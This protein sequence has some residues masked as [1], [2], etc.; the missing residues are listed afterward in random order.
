M[1]DSTTLE[2]EPPPYVSSMLRIDGYAEIEEILRSK[3]FV[4]GSHRESR[5]FF[6]DSLL[7][8][9]GGDHLARRRLESRL[10]AKTALVHYESASLTPTIAQSIHESARASGSDGPVR[11]D[12]TPLVRTMLHRISAV[13]TGIDGVE[14]PEQTERFRIFVEKLGESSTV[15]WSTR[16]RDEVIREGLEQ[17]AQ[18]VREFFGP[19]ENRRRA[20]IARYRAGEI[21]RDELPVDLLTLLHLHW[22]EQWDEDL[23]LRESTLFL[24][25][26][27]QTTT[28][29]LPHV[30]LHVDE[31]IRAHPEDRG[32]T[33][34]PEFL[35]LA[36]EESLRLH[37]PA[38]TLL[39]S[40]VRDV[41]L[42]S[43]RRI[44]KGERVALFFTPANRDRTV[45]GEDADAFNPYR[46]VPDR[47]RPWGLTFGGGVHLCIGRPLVTGLSSRND[48]ETGTEGTMVGILRALY[49]AGAQLDPDHPPRR[50]ESSY[51]DS[52]ASFPIVLTAL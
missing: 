18:F 28:H 46:T 33:T 47:R 35:R 8:L 27:T 31:W 36:A 6:A 1:A 52:Y 51:H 42:D 40:A 23:P 10:L 2:P 43:G 44:A 37:Q 7:V 13:V 49:E 30:M 12:L 16:D 11:V 14:T 50:T 39:R 32:R 34:D 29:A 20:L 21:E 48:E 9:D 38:P 17:R 25:A 26:A 19:S 3:D 22:D 15:E 41:E 4:Q 45:F 24:V 5:A